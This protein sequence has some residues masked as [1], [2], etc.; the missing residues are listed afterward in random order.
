MPEKQTKTADNHLAQIVERGGGHIE[1]HVREKI[2]QVGINRDDWN[3]GA[4]KYNG[5]L[6][7]PTVDAIL[8]D[9]AEATKHAHAELSNSGSH[10]E[11]WRRSVELVVNDLNRLLLEGKDVTAAIS[12]A[13]TLVAMSALDMISNFENRKGFVPRVDTFRNPI[14]EDAIENGAPGMIDILYRAARD[15]EKIGLCV[16][17]T[18]FR[19][20]NP[21]P[22]DRFVENT[23]WNAREKVWSHHLEANEAEFARRQPGENDADMARLADIQGDTCEHATSGG[24]INSDVYMRASP[25]EYIQG[26]LKSGNYTAAGADY[27]L[28]TMHDNVVKVHEKGAAAGQTDTYNSIMVENLL[29]SIPRDRLK[30]IAKLDDNIIEKILLHEVDNP[31]LYSFQLADMAKLLTDINDCDP[32]DLVYDPRF[33]SEL[34]RGLLEHDDYRTVMLCSHLDISLSLFDLKEENY[35]NAMRT[36]NSQMDKW[37]RK[38]LE[39]VLSLPPDVARDFRV[40]SMLRLRHV[41]NDDFDDINMIDDVDNIQPGEWDAKKEQGMSGN[42]ELVNNQ[43][44]NNVLIK[45]DRAVRTVGVDKLTEIYKQT[46]II[47]FDYYS[48]DQ[49]IRMHDVMNGNQAVIEDIKEGDVTVVFMD[50]RGD[51]NSAFSENP[52]IYEKPSGRTLFFEVHQQSDLYRFSIALKNM[53]IKDSTRVL[54]THGGKMGLVFGINDRFAIGTSDVSFDWQKNIKLGDPSVLKGMQRIAKEFMSDSRGIDDPKDRIGRRTLILE[55]CMQGQ[56]LVD[57]NTG[58]PSRP[59]TAEGFLR[60]LGDARFD[61]VAA[62]VSISSERDGNKLVWK[63]GQGVVMNKVY[64]DGE[65]EVH[66][67]AL[68]V[69]ELY[70]EQD[71]A[72]V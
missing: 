60:T 65:G 48:P 63:G 28:R 46:G 27:L 41:D 70:K 71:E 1:A 19:E 34:T 6:E 32:I 43:A 67:D 66:K 5:H 16:D 51:H 36:A 62:P 39:K 35:E 3:E 33:E 61:V 22:L 44:L 4:D 40:V 55:S 59:T 18:P 21:Q 50:A 11:I 42:V 23:I 2:A 25:H 20:P 45:L 15:A 57:K 17:K 53:G 14:I 49:L 8:S 13:Q 64:I 38:C 24:F 54:A 56:Q 29:G 31:H 10:E 47:N 58:Q 69:F 52:F 72:T 7:Q 30:E 37:I 9:I 26:L 68:E 12:K